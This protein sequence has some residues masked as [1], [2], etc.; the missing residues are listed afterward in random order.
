MSKIISDLNTRHKPTSSRAKGFTLIEISIVLVIASL[1]IGSLLGPLA[2][3]VENA[4]R[5]ATINQMENMRDAV[6]G[7]AMGSGRLPCPDTDGDGIEDPVDGIGGCDDNEGLLPSVTLAISG[8]D[9][10]KQEMLYLVDDAYAD[11][12]DG[13][14][15]GTPE[16]GISFE[17]C[18]QGDITIRDASGGNLVATNVP[19]LFISRG[20]NWTTDRSPNEVENTDSD[21]EVVDRIYTGAVGAEYDDIVRWISPNTLRSKMVDAGRFTSP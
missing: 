12:T 9:G 11:D 16:A 14:G 4:R 17:L 19:V 21:R 8:E 2:T 3:Q 6:V 1:L 13:T 18:S 15:C 20:K 10:W 7:Y 5:K